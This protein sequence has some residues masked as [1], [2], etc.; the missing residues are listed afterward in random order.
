MY[1]HSNIRICV[2]ISF[3]VSL[4]PT[5]D[6]N[7]QPADLARNRLGQ[8]FT[9]GLSRRFEYE[10]F[11]YICQYWLVDDLF[12]TAGEVVSLEHTGGQELIALDTMV[13]KEFIQTEVC[14]LSIQKS[15]VLL[16]EL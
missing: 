7:L 3:R 15:L 11:P 12:I 13:Q 9:G 8:T 16:L 1:L 6:I 14:W 2:D 10:T 4:S 5:A